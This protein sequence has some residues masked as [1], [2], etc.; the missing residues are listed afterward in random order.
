[1]GEAIKDYDE[2]LLYGSTNARME[3][4]NILQ[5]DLHFLKVKI[6]TKP[7]NTMT[8]NQG[9]AFVRDYFPVADLRS[10][11]RFTNTSVK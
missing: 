1:M 5:T 6:E 2:I 8:E 10:N 9:N 4:L 11:I 3:L 7:G